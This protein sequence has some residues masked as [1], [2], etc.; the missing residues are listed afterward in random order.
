MDQNRLSDL[1]SLKDAIDMQ[2]EIEFNLNGKHYLLEPVYDKN[3]IDAVGWSLSWDQGEKE[4][5]INST[6]FDKILDTKIDN[7]P[8]KKQ[9][10][11]MKMIFY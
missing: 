10:K 11:K 9:W 3:G 1:D 6:N 5:N 4:I 8:L 7:I 2:M